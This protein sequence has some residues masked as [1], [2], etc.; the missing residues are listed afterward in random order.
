MQELQQYN[1]KKLKR[2]LSKILLYKSFEK[3][4]LPWKINVIVVI[5]G[6]NLINL[7]SVM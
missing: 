7:L 5:S 6:K 1:N 2:K 3:Y 4:S